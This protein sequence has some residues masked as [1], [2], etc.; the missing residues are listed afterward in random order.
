MNPNFEHSTEVPTSR[1]PRLS[2]RELIR[3]AVIFAG[4]IV[5]A[6]LPEAVKA[7]I[8]LPTE[9][10]RLA[11]AQLLYRQFESPEVPETPEIP[12]PT[13][14]DDSNEPLAV[15][16]EHSINQVPV[17]PSPSPVPSAPNSLERSPSSIAIEIQG[18]MEKVNIYP[19]FGTSRTEVFNREVVEYRDYLSNVL[20][21]LKKLN[22]PEID[23][24]VDRFF[25]TTDKRVSPHGRSVATLY[26]TETWQ[27]EPKATYY[28]FFAETGYAS[29][30]P[31]DAF[32][33]FATRTAVIRNTPPNTGIAIVSLLH[34]I[35]FNDLKATRGEELIKSGVNPSELR[36]YFSTDNNRLE[37][38]EI[39]LKTM[40]K[41]VDI[42]SRVMDRFEQNGIENTR[43]P[44]LLVEKW[45]EIEK[46]TN[47]SV[48][49]KYLQLKL[50]NEYYYNNSVPE[51]ELR[52]ASKK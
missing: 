29:Q 43:N 4:G 45:L 34:T 42:Y 14:V 21:N 5:L 25:A 38:M 13:D 19:S 7:A 52:E 35:D 16:T 40:K 37:I 12:S 27:P 31:S 33:N 9:R 22:D 10:T 48:E 49:K 8:I 17:R 11:P 23:G 46:S 44:R 28:P 30:F 47:N 26:T 50:Q 41:Y 32:F 6:S 2:R 51:E 15:T 18:K 1:I 39:R 36:I 3:S 20:I 24:Y